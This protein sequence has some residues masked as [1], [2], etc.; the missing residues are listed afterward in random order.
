MAGQGQP[1]RRVKA[2]APDPVKLREDDQRQKAQ[3]RAEAF[4]Q[5]EVKAHLGDAVWS[6][7][8]GDVSAGDVAA[9][10]SATGTTVI[11]P[12]LNMLTYFEPGVTVVALDKLAELIFLARRQAGERPTFDDVADQITARAEVWIEFPAGEMPDPGEAQFLDPP[13]SDGS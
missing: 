2:S 1:P 13:A 3:Q 11:D 7:A 6:F 9:L 10:R 5:F 12:V 4:N 8:A